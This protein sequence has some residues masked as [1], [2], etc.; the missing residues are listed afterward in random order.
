MDGVGVGGETGVGDQRPS[1]PTVALLRRPPIGYKKGVR[2]RRVW[3]T[4]GGCGRPSSPTPYAAVCVVPSLFAAAGG[5]QPRATPISARSRRGLPVGVRVAG[6]YPH[7]CCAHPSQ[8]RT[9]KHPLGSAVPLFHSILSLVFLL[10]RGPLR[11]P[12][13]LPRPLLRGRS[14]EEVP[15]NASSSP[16]TLLPHPSPVPSWVLSRVAAVICRSLPLPRRPL[17]QVTILPFAAPRSYPSPSHPAPI[18]A[19][20]WAL[21]SPPRPATAVVGGVC[22]P[23]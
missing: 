22:A 16:S 7:R 6:G 4:G 3:A 18:P 8:T 1:F 9:S 5:S 11:S 12:A 23:Y 15:S 17:L 13:P 19:P 10:C 20:Q 21:S 2:G 14:L